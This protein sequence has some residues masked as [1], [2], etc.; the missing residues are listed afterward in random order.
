MY[1]R[2]SVD[3]APERVEFKLGEGKMILLIKK[4]ADKH[5][6]IRFHAVKVISPFSSCLRLYFVSLTPLVGKLYNLVRDSRKA[7]R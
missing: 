6:S 3:L 4:Q 1:V 5:S 2:T 7:I